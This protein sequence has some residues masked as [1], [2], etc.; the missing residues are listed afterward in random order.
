MHIQSSPSYSSPHSGRKSSRYPQSLWKKKEQVDKVGWVVVLEGVGGGGG[1]GL[2][3]LESDLARLSSRTKATPQSR[4]EEEPRRLAGCSS[5]GCRLCW[6]LF[7]SDWAGRVEVSRPA[8]SQRTPLSLLC[9]CLSGH[10]LKSEVN[11]HP[12]GCRERRW[13]RQIW[14]SGI[15]SNDCLVHRMRTYPEWSP[16]F[17]RWSPTDSWQAFVPG[18]LTCKE[19]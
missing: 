8:C 7:C 13:I 10:M 14:K 12:V 16:T 9:R 5:R 4:A 17:L 1:D 2:E 15:E 19:L 3:Q 18:S 6:C 11:P